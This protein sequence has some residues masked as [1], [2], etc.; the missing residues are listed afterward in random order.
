MAHKGTST[1][2]HKAHGRTAPH[3]AEHLRKLAEV[4]R[5]TDPKSNHVA[6][7][8]AAALEG[9]AGHIASREI[10]D[11]RL[12]TLSRICR[13]TGDNYRYEPGPQQQRLFGMLGMDI[14]TPLPEH[15]LNELVAAAAD[16]FHEL[17]QKRVGELRKEVN[18]MQEDWQRIAAAEEKAEK[19]EARSRELDAELVTERDAVRE[20]R[21]QKHH[22][23]QMLGGAGEPPPLPEAEGAKKPRRRAIDGHTGVYEKWNAQ[24]EMSLEIGWREDN[25]KRWL[26]V[27]HTDVPQAVKERE[28]ILDELKAVPA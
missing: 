10:K 14:V 28:Q 18:K 4:A 26:S 2:N 1:L 16:D 22:L 15:S 21:A 9:L 19:A 25:K 5:S 12:Y 7:R 27:G 8:H 20:L 23:E 6:P 11:E 3:I 17:V 24:G 13:F